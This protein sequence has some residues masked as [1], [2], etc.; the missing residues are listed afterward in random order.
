VQ[1]FTATYNTFYKITATAQPPNLVGFLYTP[2]PS[3]DGFF[4]GGTQ[5]S[6]TAVAQNGYTFKNWSGDLSGTN[7]TA[8]LVMNA[9]HFV[10]AVLNG[11]PYVSAVQNSASVTLSLTVGPGSLISIIGDDLSATSKTSPSGELLQAIDDVWVTVNN[12]LLPLLYIS[13]TMI[14]AQ[15][16]SDLVDGPYTLTVHRTNQGDASQTFTV[17]R[18]SPGLFQLSPAQGS[19]TVTAFRADGT[20][21]TPNNPATANETI[22]FFGTGFG[23][24][25]RPMVDGFPTPDTGTWNVLDPVT[26]T[27]GGQTYTP[28]STTAA[29]GFAGLVAVQV[30]L[31]TLPSGLVN[32][33]VTVNNV[34]SN[35][36]QLPIK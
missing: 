26:V 23:L 27:A 18:D 5:V 4:P 3:A 35:T 8:S 30:K 10:T 14:N 16:F 34:D 15:L 24:Y 1:V 36:V 29:N 2:S 20:L 22:T 17:K 31:G 11:F 13:P 25:D 19:P 28:I 21:L 12:R 7:P 6:I 9:E 33:K 32:L